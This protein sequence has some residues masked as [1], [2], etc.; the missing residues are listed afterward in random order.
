MSFYLYFQRVRSKYAI[1]N[2]ME[3]SRKK[4][5]YQLMLAQAEALFTGET[6]AIANLANASALL[7][8]TLPNTVF[9]GFYLYDGSELVL[10]PFQG[11]V[12]CVRIALGKGV[13]GEVAQSQ[14]A[15]IVEDVTKHANYIACDSAA[16]SEIV[17]PMLKDGY[18]LGVLDLDSQK[19]ADYDDL[20]LDFLQAF[21]EIVLSKTEWNFSM[22]EVRA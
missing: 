3:K 16:R 19:V 12:S 14:K 9:A 8:E 1:I 4:E 10:G 11:H 17:L 15:M 6:N 20:D 22:F 7:R 2:S 13:C 5:N 18:L 21:L